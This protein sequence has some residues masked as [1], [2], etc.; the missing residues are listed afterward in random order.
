MAYGQQILFLGVSGFTL[1]LDFADKSS[2]GEGGVVEKNEQAPFWP[3]LSPA[4]DFAIWTIIASSRRL[5]WHQP[6]QGDLGRGG[7]AFN[8]YIFYFEEDQA[9]G[10]HCLGSNAE[11]DQCCQQCKRHSWKTAMRLRQNQGGW[12]WCSK[13]KAIR[14]LVLLPVKEPVSLLQLWLCTRQLNTDSRLLIQHRLLWQRFA[15]FFGHG[16]SPSR[17]W[18]PCKTF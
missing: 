12:P 13:Q 15:K 17:F 10:I 5:Q 3:L 6:N 2:L 8:I 18:E 4:P 11:I 1:T 9:V 7:A 16:L 14:N